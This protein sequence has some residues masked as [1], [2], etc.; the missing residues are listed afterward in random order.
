MPGP[1]HRMGI[2]Q[3]S[4]SRF[5]FGETSRPPDCGPAAW[6]VIGKTLAPTR[7]YVTGRLTLEA[8][9]ARLEQTALP[10]RQGRL[11]L[12]YLTLSRTRP[13]PRDELVEAL[14]PTHAPRSADTALSAV[15]SKLRSGLT[16]IGLDGAATLDSAAGCYQLRLPPGTEVDVETAANSLD[17][18]EG[19][20]RAGDVRAAWASATVATAILRRPL[21]PG[22]DAPWLIARRTDLRNLLLR[23]YDCLVEIWTEQGDTTL[24]VALAKDALAIAPYRESGYRRLM[25]AHAA[26]GDRADALRVFERCRA[27]LREELGVDPSQ[28]TQAVYLAVLNK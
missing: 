9:D 22:D 12:A 20:R 8:G 15:V 6:Q 17:R 4:P 3:P 14:W 13:V 27:L 1:R 21:L 24:A 23:A 2:Q 19:S 18:A 7:V 5:P 26:A 25:H 28:E 11:A 10:G 16:R